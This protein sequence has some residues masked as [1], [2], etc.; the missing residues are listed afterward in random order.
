[1]VII[2]KAQLKKGV[3]H[4]LHTVILSTVLLPLGWLPQH[5]MHISATTLSKNDHLTV[6]SHKTMC[7]LKAEA[8]SQPKFKAQKEQN[9]R[10]SAGSDL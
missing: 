7:S 10:A 3:I 8:S 4:D 2:L 6:S 9:R 5:T 1:M